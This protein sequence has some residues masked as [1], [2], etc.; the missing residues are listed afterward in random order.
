MYLFVCLFIYLF[1]YLFCLFNNY[2]VSELVISFVILVIS[3]TAITHRPTVPPALSPSVLAPSLS[4]T[5]SANAGIFCE[6][7][8]RVTD[9]YVMNFG[10]ISCLRYVFMKFACMQLLVLNLGSTVGSPMAGATEQFPGTPSRV[11][12]KVL[13]TQTILIA[14][15]A[16]INLLVLTTL[17]TLINLL[18]FMFIS[19]TYELVDC[20][21]SKCIGFVFA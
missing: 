8:Q 20:G 3:K 5:P 6:I 4:T 10:Y 14:L 9:Q 13:L 18:V 19:Y 17:I 11:P 16:L 7:S 2:L 15:I 21:Q 1:I 12:A